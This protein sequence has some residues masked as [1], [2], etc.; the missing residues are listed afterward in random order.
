[1]TTVDAANT[2]SRVGIGQNAAPLDLD[3][4]SVV[5]DCVIS[6]LAYIRQRQAQNACRFKLRNF[7]SAPERAA[8]EFPVLACY[9]LDALKHDRERGIMGIHGAQSDFLKER[10][11][12]ARSPCINAW[13]LTNDAKCVRRKSAIDDAAGAGHPRHPRRGCVLMRK[14]VRDLLI[15]ETRV[16]KAV[17]VLDEYAQ[18]HA[19]HQSVQSRVCHAASPLPWFC[20]TYERISSAPIPSTFSLSLA[21]SAG[22]AG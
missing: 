10:S 9:R 19:A 5:S 14:K 15:S 11:G 16:S 8:S 22:C 3:P 18:P 2:L 1:M 4:A 17:E 6:S 21:A 7:T 12:G 13:R 20:L